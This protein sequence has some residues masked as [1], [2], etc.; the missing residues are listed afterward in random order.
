MA[1]LRGLVMPAKAGIQFSLSFD[2]ESKGFRSPFR[3]ASH[4]L[5]LR[6]EKVT[7]EKATPAMRS[8]GIRQLLLHCSTS[9][10]HAVACP[11][12]S[13]VCSGVRRQHFRVLTSNWARSI[14]PTLRAFSPQPRRT[15]GVPVA[16]I[17]RAKAK[18][19]LLRCSPWMDGFVDPGAVRG[20]EH[21]R[22]GGNSPK[23]RGDGSPRLRSSTGTYC[24]SNRLGEK[25]RGRCTASGA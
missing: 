7:K 23:G 13:R 19:S 9:G 14:A 22:R 4:F 10:I 12:S 15:A 8:P 18:K 24:L 1:Y 16:R 5:L 25:R 11:P 20:A 17:V 3:R 6:Q 21:R 2:I